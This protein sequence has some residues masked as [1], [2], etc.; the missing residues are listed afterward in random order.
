MMLR[1]QQIHTSHLIFYL[2]ML[3]L[4][5]L[6]LKSVPETTEKV[7]YRKLGFL[8][9]FFEI[10]AVM[11]RTNAGLTDSHPYDSRPLDWIFLKR[12]ISFWG[13]QHRHI[14][15]LG[16]PIVW[17]SGSASIAIYMIVKVLLCIRAKRGY[18]DQL[19]GK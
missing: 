10:N 14:Y 5:L 13:K 6:F 11:W 12:G 19:S 8:D 17:W 3:T 2:P 1:I 9:K 7:N 4:L 15:L 18:D 16:N